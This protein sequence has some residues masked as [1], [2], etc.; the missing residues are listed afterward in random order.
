MRCTGGAALGL[1]DCTQGW[2]GYCCYYGYYYLAQGVGDENQLPAAGLSDGGEL[3][4]TVTGS[5]ILLHV[6]YLREQFHGNLYL[7]KRNA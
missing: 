6:N 1:A 4:N 3:M 5:G 7:K 2:L